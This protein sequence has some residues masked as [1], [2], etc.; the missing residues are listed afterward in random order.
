MIK[1]SLAFL[2]MASIAA[3]PAAAQ[4]PPVGNNM[5]VQA[6]KT[7]NYTIKSTDLK[8]MIPFNCS[9]PCTVTLPHSTSSWPKGY[10]VLIQD[11]GSGTVTVTAITSTIYGLP[12]TGGNIPLTNSGNWASFTAD[13]A[14]NYLAYGFVGS[15][16]GGGGGILLTCG[17]N[18]CTCGTSLC[19]E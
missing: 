4:S 14:N 12:T 9:A 7:G 17:T 19:T 6:T 3:I 16:G 10:P 15:G 11:I 1:K 8:T 2:I 5:P 18:L 13:A